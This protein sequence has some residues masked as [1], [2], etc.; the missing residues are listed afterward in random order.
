M[1]RDLVLLCAHEYAKDGAAVLTSSGG[2]VLQ[3]NQK[4]LATLS[5]FIS[6]FQR[7]KKL[8]VE[9]RTYV[10]DQSDV[11]IEENYSSTYDF[12]C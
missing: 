12:C 2:C 6:Q 9:N 11:S 3:M 8:S 7:I 1:P 10:V 5:D 4:E